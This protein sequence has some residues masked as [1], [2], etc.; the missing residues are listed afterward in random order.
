MINFIIALFVK[1]E[2]LTE[3]EGRKL[4]KAV[5]GRP[6][7]DEYDLALAFVERLLVEAKLSSTRK[8]FDPT[9]LEKKKDKKVDIASKK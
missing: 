9:L 2:L 6:I 5:F 1:K 7:P 8:Y 3:E 4:S